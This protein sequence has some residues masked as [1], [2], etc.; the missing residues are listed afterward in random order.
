MAFAATIAAGLDGLKNKIE[1][2]D[3]FEGDVYEAAD[4]PKVPLSLGQATDALENSE[5][6][7]EAFGQ[8][9]IDHY[10]HF[11]RVEQQ[12]FDEVVTSWERERYFERA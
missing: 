6:L 12:K 8:E 7:K 1:P 11:F 3:I 4:L 9:V 10:V 2:A 5:M